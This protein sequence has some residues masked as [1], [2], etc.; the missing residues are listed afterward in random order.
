MAIV[1]KTFTEG[2]GIFSGMDAEET[3][4]CSIRPY[5]DGLTD[6]D[7][8]GFCLRQLPVPFLAAHTRD[9]TLKEVQGMLKDVTKEDELELTTSLQRLA[10]R[11]SSG[12]TKAQER[13]TQLVPSNVA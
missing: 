9:S 13:R 11:D 1:I 10:L 4:W 5:A 8:M 2:E 3:L 7:V 12:G 6:G